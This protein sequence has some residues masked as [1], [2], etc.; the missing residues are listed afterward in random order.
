MEFRFVT[1]A[2]MQSTTGLKPPIQTIFLKHSERKE[3][4]KIS[5]ISKKSLQNRP[6]SPYIISLQCELFNTPTYNYTE[7]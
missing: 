4:S 5:K 7:D 1:V 2:R 6:F 3:Y